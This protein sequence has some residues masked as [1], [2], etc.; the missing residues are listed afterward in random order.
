MVFQEFGLTPS[1]KIRELFEKV[2]TPDN[3]QSDI[4]SYRESSGPFQCDKHTFEII[5][6][7]ELRRQKRNQNSFMIMLLHIN[8]SKQNQKSKIINTLSNL[9]RESDCITLWNQKLIIAL[10][11][12]G[13]K[14]AGQIIKKRLSEVMKINNFKLSIKLQLIEPYHKNKLLNEIINKT[15]I[16]NSIL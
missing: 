10:L 15:N 8:E 6:E 5:Y 9:L 12:K 13:S 3:K 7:L 14:K 2:D 11:F 1:F 16:S 4:I